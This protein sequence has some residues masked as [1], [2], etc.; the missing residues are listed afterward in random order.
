[1]RILNNTLEKVTAERS[2][3]S[4]E[5]HRTKE[6]SEKIEEQLR[7]ANDVE[8]WEKL[9]R[10]TKDTADFYQ[11]EVEKMKSFVQLR[12]E[13]VTNLEKEVQILR[14]ALNIQKSYE[15]E[16]GS[17]INNNGTIASNASVKEIIKALYYDLGRSQTESHNLAI[18]LAEKHKEI[19]NMI[20]ELNNLRKYKQDI[21][22]QI[23]QL[24]NHVD[25]L[26][27][28][29]DMRDRIVEALQGEADK[30]KNTS[31]LYENQ[32]EN[33]TKRLSDIETNNEQTLK[34][35]EKVIEDLQA[36]LPKAQREAVIGKVEILSVS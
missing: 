34:E 22:P 28:Q 18:T 4:H 13:N 35:K 32:I 23:E 5:F 20:D 21:G 19:E 15:A 7:R 8:S 33:L 9:I 30:Y 25:D 24:L 29:L 1:M 17:I 2:K 27:E 26:T 31:E 11:G 3:L 36:V 6:H 12:E 10:D 14:R 16:F